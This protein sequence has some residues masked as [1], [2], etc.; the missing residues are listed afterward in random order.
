[1]DYR[2]WPRG[3]SLIEVLVAMA[4]VALLAISLVTTTLLTQRSARTA[5]NNTQA[6]N[7]V[8]QSIERVRVYRDRVGYSALTDTSG[9]NC[10]KLVTEADPADPSMWVLSSAGCPETIIFNNTSFNR[11]IFIQTSS[12]RKQITVTVEWQD[13][14]GLQTVKS[15]TYL[16]NCVLTSS[17]C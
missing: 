14:S 5:R 1:M 7:L 6:T 9:P 2:L 17:G 3:Q 4:I 8:Q 16:S 13:S 15:V 12:N 10:V 11:K